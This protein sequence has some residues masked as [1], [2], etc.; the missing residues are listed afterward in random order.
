MYSR[1]GGVLLIDVGP[2]L[3]GD[4]GRVRPLVE[5]SQDAQPDLRLPGP[6]DSPAE[7][8]PALIDR[9]Q[10]GEAQD[11]EFFDAYSIYHHQSTCGLDW[12]A[13]PLDSQIIFTPSMCNF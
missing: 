7:A 11:V 8:E 2:D 12:A 10:R 13:R 3:T 6:D 4:L 1:W 9:W 5:G